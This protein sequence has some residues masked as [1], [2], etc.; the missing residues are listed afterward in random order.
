M[1][2]ESVTQA[3]NKTF[4]SLGNEISQMAIKFFSVHTSTNHS[5]CSLTAGS[6]SSAFC[7]TITGIPVAKECRMFH[8]FEISFYPT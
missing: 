3:C 8:N 2:Y 5:P 1:D 6:V 7:I 4:S